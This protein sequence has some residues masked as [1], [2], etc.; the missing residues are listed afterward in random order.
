M[1][2]FWFFWVE[3][4]N[5][6]VKKFPKNV[7]FSNSWAPLKEGFVN[8]KGVKGV[9]QWVPP[10]DRYTCLSENGSQICWSLSHNDIMLVKL[11]LF[12]TLQ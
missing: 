5:Y 1:K 10:P 2:N 9:K 7:A 4:T 6:I 12:Q 8:E 11:I 3:I